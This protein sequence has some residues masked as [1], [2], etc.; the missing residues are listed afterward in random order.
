MRTG[1]HSEIKHLMFVYRGGSETYVGWMHNEIYGDRLKM[2]IDMGWPFYPTARF[3][4]VYSTMFSQT[5]N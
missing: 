1:I 4:R 3:V 5:V 2:A